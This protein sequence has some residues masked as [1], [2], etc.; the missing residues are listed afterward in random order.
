MM[1]VATSLESALQELESTFVDR[2]CVPCGAPTRCSPSVREPACARCFDEAERVD[3]EARAARFAPIRGFDS[4]VPPRYAWAKLTSPELARRVKPSA[5][6]REIDG[7]I[8]EPWVIFAGAS[9]AGKTSLAV[10][11]LRERIRRQRESWTMLLAFRLGSA[12]IQHRAGAGEAPL[13]DLAMKT[14]FLLLDDVGQEPKTEMNPISDILQERDAEQRPTWI[15]TGL[16]RAEIGL[17]YGGGVGR[18]VIDRSRIVMLDS[19]LK[20]KS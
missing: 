2:V 17:R 20:E 14:P 9:G 1:A 19:D 15:T 6:I 16:T 10:A 5:R 13:V 4:T 18:R 7:F 3:A 8:S 12:R 11:A